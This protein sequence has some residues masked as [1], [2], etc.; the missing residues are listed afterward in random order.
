MVSHQSRCLNEYEILYIGPYQKRCKDG[1]I[2]HPDLRPSHSSGRIVQVNHAQLEN[3]VS[4][5]QATNSS[6]K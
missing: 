3:G 6:K 4:S 5:A 2:G 1:S